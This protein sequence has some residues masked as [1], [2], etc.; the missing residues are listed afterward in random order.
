MDRA[1]WWATAHRVAKELD[2]TE[3]THYSS[4]ELGSRKG[5]SRKELN[6]CHDVKMLES[7]LGKGEKIRC[8]VAM[9]MWHRRPG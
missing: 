5:Q 9:G 8:G 7:I 4:L 2:R 6:Q 3:H 1:A